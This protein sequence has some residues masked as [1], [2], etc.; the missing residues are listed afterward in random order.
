MLTRGE[1]KDLTLGEHSDGLVLRAGVEDIG[2]VRAIVAALANA[3]TD[4]VWKVAECS[5]DRSLEEVVGEAL[6]A[7]R[8]PPRVEI[9]SGDGQAVVA[10]EAAPLGAPPCWDG[11]TLWLPASGGPRPASSSEVLVRLDRA[12]LATCELAPIEG[13]LWDELPAGRRMAV[14]A[15]QEPAPLSRAVSLGAALPEGGVT[16]AGAGCLANGARVAL[17]EAL[18]F[19]LSWF[20]SRRPE[21]LARGDEPAWI[22]PSAPPAVSAV[23]SLAA[24]L[25]ARILT[26][27]RNRVVA[28][29][30]IRELLTNALVHRSFLSI[31]LLTP[32]RVRS[33]PDALEVESPGA[34]A[35]PVVVNDGWFTGTWS[36]NPSLHHLAERL[37]LAHQQGI[38]GM[39][40]RDLAKQLGWGTVVDAT[41]QS[42]TV[43][44]ERPRQGPKPESPVR[45][46][47]LPRA[48]VSRL[49]L[50][51]LA[52]S[53]PLAA[54]EIA[55]RLGTASSTTRAVLKE[56]AVAGRVQRTKSGRSAP[57]QRYHLA[58]PAS[59]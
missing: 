48:E 36:R 51:L 25:A 19:E 28:E 20:R 22:G 24:E 4:G 23:H 41:E 5:S 6:R 11:E 13:L 46:R 21:S 45:R 1:A 2:E 17:P 43:R 34:L 44:L 57:N 29:A 55:D 15:L 40:I 53:Q 32:I 35:G 38:G 7:L 26:G 8:H 33:F 16:L 47:G 54:K 12:G 9:Y 49:V 18:S 59:A 52:G 14:H 39:R 50:E 42:V 58:D 31:H 56:L 3:G 30:L 10:V 37:G 27:S